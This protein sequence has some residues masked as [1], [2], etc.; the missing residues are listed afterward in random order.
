MQV[1]E[2]PLEVLEHVGKYLSPVEYHRLRLSAR[3]GLLFQQLTRLSTLT[4]PG[5]FKKYYLW[6][7]K[8]AYSQLIRID[9][10]LI[11]RSSWI[12]VQKMFKKKYRGLDEIYLLCLS[13]LMQTSPVWFEPDSTALEVACFHN[14][15][16]LVEELIKTVDPGIQEQIAFRTACSRGH[17]DLVQFLLQ[18]PRVDPSAQS[19][20][21]LRVAA[22]HGCL[23][24]VKVLLQ[25]GPIDSQS[26][27]IAVCNACE[28]GHTEIVKTFLQDSDIMSRTHWIQVLD[29]AKKFQHEEI[30]QL[31]L[32]Q[33]SLP[34][35]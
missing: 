17:L 20:F 30:I 9:L 21:G 28:N 29:Q 27:F 13:T 14:R 31:I 25:H 2:L 23:E 32:D 7:Y 18:D 11:P 34:S 22:D 35:Q 10:T 3:T 12:A 6:D 8:D 1:H 5:Y 16:D 24:I 15:G 26:G 19:H 4:Q 33:C